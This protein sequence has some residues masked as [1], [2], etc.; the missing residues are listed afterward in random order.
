MFS[1]AF[2]SLSS[3][4]ICA[5]VLVL[6][7]PPNNNANVVDLGYAKYAGNFTAPHSVAY[8]G[9]PFAEPP[10]GD[11]RWRAPVS[12]DTL[13]ISKEARGQVIDARSYPNFCIQGGT[14]GML[15]QILHMTLGSHRSLSWGCWWSG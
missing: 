3:L 8:L 7:A 12:L 15:L 9:L 14:G 2:R 6:G 5:S 13:R 4:A 1:W 11:R 10:V